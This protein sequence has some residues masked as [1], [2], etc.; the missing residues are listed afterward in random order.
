[1]TDTPDMRQLVP[2]FV[3]LVV[4]GSAGVGLAGASPQPAPVCSVCGPA[5]ENAAERHGVD[6]SVERSTAVIEVHENETATWT[7]ENELSGGAEQFREEPRI[8]ERTA[9]NPAH[10]LVPADPEL[11]SAGMDGDVAVLTYEEVGAVERHAGLLVYTGLEHDGW[12]SY[13]LT[14]DELVVRGPDGTVVTNDPE[15]GKVDSSGAG[16]LAGSG[17]DEGGG[18]A[19]IWHGDGSVGHYHEAPRFDERPLVVFGPG[20]AAGSVATDVRT[21]AALGLSVLPQVVSNLQ[22]FFFVQTLVFAGVLAGPIIV[23]R[24][25]AP[26]TDVHIL[27]GLLVAIGILGVASASVAGYVLLPPSLLALLAGFVGLSHRAR[28]ALAAPHRL[29]LA[30]GGLLVAVFAVQVAVYASPAQGLFSH[31]GIQDPVLT[32]LEG[33]ALVVPLAALLPL[34]AAALGERR[35]LLGWWALTTA[36]FAFVPAVVVNV[37]EPVTGLTGLA[38]IVL[39]LVAVALPIVGS[40]M[41]ALGCVLTKPTP[42]DS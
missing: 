38:T 13:Y 30:G 41:L 18:S 11:V 4:A 14:V 25:E 37:T 27:G 28:T 1:M 15:G 3:L 8:L 31:R 39:L 16:E 35:R 22:R 19:A 36:S 40:P 21:V 6:V 24:K 12:E 10:D 29:A 17:T 23:L 26:R 5:F 2:V 20:D 33:T 32:S 42:T 9:R 7:I 34:G